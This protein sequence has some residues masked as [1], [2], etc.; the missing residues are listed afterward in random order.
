M[1]ATDQQDQHGSQ[2]DQAATTMRAIVQEAYGTADVLRPATIDM[3]TPGDDEVLVRVRAAGMDRGTWHLMTG[4]PRMARLMTGLRTPKRRVP[5]LD[6]AGTVVS[7]GAD[8]TR[9]SPGD[10]VFGIGAG[11]YAEYAVAREAKLARKPAT[12]TFEQ[13]AVVPVSGLTALQAVRDA[14]R[15]QAGQRVLVTGASGGV[16]TYAV[17]IAAAL[18]AEVTGVCSAPKADLVRSLGAVDVIDYAH[19]D[20]SDRG[21]KYDV[22][23]D[24]NGNTGVL[25]LMGSLTPRGCAAIVGGENGGTWTGGF[26]GRPIRAMALS[27]FSRKRLSMVMAKETGVDL[28]K[29]TTMIEAGQVTPAV[30]TVFPLADTADAMRR[31]EAGL[32][33]GKIAISI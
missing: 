31:L 18:G 28:E 1:H 5:G 6:L 33:R 13:A 21:E 11:S 29:L 12:L 4:L 16:G 14:G 17:Q 22:I 7:V 2:Q 20:F 19:E 10:E 24:I 25:R 30:D 9:F 32:V 23:I 26:L 15:V 27:L 8:V 3:P